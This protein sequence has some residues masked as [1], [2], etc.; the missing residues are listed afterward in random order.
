LQIETANDAPRLLALI[1]RLQTTRDFQKF[2]SELTARVWQ[3]LTAAA[4]DLEL[5]LVL[6][7]MAEEPLQM[8]GNHDTCPDGI[9]LEFNQMEVQVFTREALRNA[10]PTERGPTLYRLTQQLF[11][12]Q[13]LD[14][15]A[16]E[17]VQ[18]RRAAGQPVDEA[19]VRLAY[20]IRL[21]ERLALPQPPGSMLYER[22]A[23][24]DAQAL[25]AA[26]A[27]VLRAQQGSAFMDYAAHRDFWVDYLRETHPGDFD[28][29]KATFAQEFTALEDRF[30]E[31]NEAYFAELNVLTLRQQE[32]ELTLLKRLT[33]ESGLAFDS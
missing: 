8:L 14:T 17:E 18:T 15:L 2:R 6:N 1:G 29:L 26:Q 12:L 19:E 4:N 11:R 9:R 27:R 32:A 33:A 13:Q 25:E 16:L 5:R 30:P 24:V 7:G 28:R 10:P 22:L 31:L 23:A 21:A 3:V 20:R